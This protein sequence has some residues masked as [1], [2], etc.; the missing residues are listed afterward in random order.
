MQMDSKTHIA[1]AIGSVT[2]ATTLGAIDYE[3]C[4]LI[5]LFIYKEK[6]TALLVYSLLF[7]AVAYTGFWMWIQDKNILDKK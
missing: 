2:L 1:I 6:L 5:E 7:M 3:T 4:S